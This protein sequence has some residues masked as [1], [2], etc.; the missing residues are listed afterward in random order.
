MHSKTQPFCVCA[1]IAPPHSQ[2]FFIMAVQRP[3]ACCASSAD[4]CAFEQGHILCITAP[5][6]CQNTP[7]P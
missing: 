1:V 3:Y 6:G 5:Q 4:M 2:H 7:Q